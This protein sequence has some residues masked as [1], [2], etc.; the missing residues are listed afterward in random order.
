M[1]DVIASWRS[2]DEQLL[3]LNRTIEA[4]VR[5]RNE[6]DPEG[7]AE[8]RAELR[9]IT[10]TLNPQV[11]TF[12][13]MLMQGEQ[14]L[15]NLLLA[16]SAL[17]LL[18]LLAMSW[19]AI[20]RLLQA[21]QR[22]EG[23]F[24]K[25]FEQAAIGMAEVGPDGQFIEVNDSLCRMLR[26]S[27]MQLIG[28]RLQRY[29]H[30][31]D[32]DAS[33]RALRQLAS[34]EKR[35]KTFDKRYIRSD[36]E[37]VWTRLTVSAIREGSDPEPRLFSI[38]EDITHARQLSDELS[39]RAS[40]DGLT[41]LWNRQELENRLQLAVQSAHATSSEHMLAFIDLDQFKVINDTCGHIAGDHMLC[42][43][44]QVLR[45]HLREHDILARLGGDEFAVL[46]LDTS[47]EGAQLASGKLHQAIRDYCFHWQGRNFSLSSSIGLAAIDRNTPDGTWV[48]QAADTACNMAKDSGRSRIHLYVEQDSA[49]AHRRREMEWVSGIREALDLDRLSLSAQKILPLTPATGCRFEV[50]VRL[51]DAEDGNTRQA[52]SCR[53]PSATT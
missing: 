28:T 38:I 49:V 7:I 19:R 17:T 20:C 30:P 45:N 24:H 26:Y 52:P 12:S 9:R 2:G 3:R 23:K 21:L 46:F 27:R 11:R 47:S 50:L 32:I 42:Q 5:A 14:V 1:A 48:L 35:F 22:A 29:T 15:R 41:G 13:D 16:T 51:T 37:T 34:G 40:H 4:A 36:G 6:P 39:Y 53:P 31:D 33:I 8:L 43:V 25:A 10:Q 18:L 44:A